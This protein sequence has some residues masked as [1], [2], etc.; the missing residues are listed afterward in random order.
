M[1]E[2]SREIK[3]RA[4]DTVN[5]EMGFVGAMDWANEND[6][7][8]ITCATL[9]NK[10]YRCEPSDFILMQYTGL[11]DKNEIEIYEGDIVR[12]SHVYGID[13]AVVIFNPKL[14]CIGWQYVKKYLEGLKGGN[15]EFLDEETVSSNIG[16]KIIGNIHENGD[17]LND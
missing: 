5:K 9:K 4:W 12:R 10:L 8:P 13:V 6:D 15:F 3:F 1:T 16:W 17:L 14:V 7:Q 11:K 2:H